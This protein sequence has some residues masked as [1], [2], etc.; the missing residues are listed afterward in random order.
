VN[1]ANVEASEAV[2]QASESVAEQVRGDA[3]HA[4]STSGPSTENTRRP[5]AERTRAV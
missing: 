1:K 4:P 5:R 3:S 2:V